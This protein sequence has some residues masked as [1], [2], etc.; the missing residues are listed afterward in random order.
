MR[1][2]Y[3]ILSVVLLLCFSE[4]KAQTESFIWLLGTWKN[5]KKDLYET[6]V[7]GPESGFV[8][9]IYKIS[10]MDTLVVEQM[11]IFREDKLYYF[12]WGNNGNPIIIRRFNFDSFFA[13]SQ[14]NGAAKKVTYQLQKGRMRKSIVDN[15]SR[16]G[17]YTLFKLE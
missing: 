13:A 4:V 17:S 12:S 7:P 2:V 10:E 9:K 14:L 1:S 3:S 15:G 5:E 11:R 8:G 16:S 6:W